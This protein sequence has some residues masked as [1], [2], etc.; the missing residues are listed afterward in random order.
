MI[1]IAVGQF[2]IRLIYSLYYIT[3]YV[4]LSYTRNTM[5]CTFSTQPTLFQKCNP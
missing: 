4:Q 2:L 1:A 3:S 5:L